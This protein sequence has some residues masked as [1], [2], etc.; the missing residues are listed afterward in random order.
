MSKTIFGV[1]VVVV[2]TGGGRYDLPAYFKAIALKKKELFK[3]KIFQHMHISILQ[4]LSFSALSLLSCMAMVMVSPAGCP[5][6]RQASDDD[7]D[8]NEVDDDEDDDD[9][10]DDEDDEDDDD[11]LSSPVSDIKGSIRYQGHPIYSHISS[12]LAEIS[13]KLKL[14]ERG[15]LIISTLKKEF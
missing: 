15:F 5:T 8:D 4:L 6:L 11:G 7:D 14:E 1:V 2:V 13:P 9:E 12:K 3:A 10:V